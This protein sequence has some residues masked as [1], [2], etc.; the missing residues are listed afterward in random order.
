M[1]S[2]HFVSTKQSAERIIKTGE[3]PANVFIV[4]APGLD[5]VLTQQ[6]KS[7]EDIEAGIGLNLSLPTALVIQHP[8]STHPETAGDEI[9]AT[10]EA[11][12]DLGLQ[13]VAVYPNSDPGHKGVIKM[14]K[15]Y[16]SNP[17]FKIYKSMPH[18]DYLSIMKYAHVMV[19]NSSSAIIE[20]PSFNL[21]V[22]N[23]GERQEGRERA[24]NVIDVP[25]EKE[26]IKSAIKTCLNDEAFRR[27]ASACKNPYGD[28]RAGSRI[29]EILEGINLGPSLIQKKLAY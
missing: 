19:G 7:K 28:G 5:T 6:V 12:D 4:G 9:K 22:V 25:Y 11:V 13:A 3:N 8:V 2:L 20:A 1:A 26:Q 24:E 17:R 15:Q 16:E 29:M 27:R 21:P 14:L 23:I 18:A 10:L